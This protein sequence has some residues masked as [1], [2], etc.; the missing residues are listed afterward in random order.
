MDFDD[1]AFALKVDNADGTMMAMDLLPQY[2]PRQIW[3]I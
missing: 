1:I 2:Q 3:G